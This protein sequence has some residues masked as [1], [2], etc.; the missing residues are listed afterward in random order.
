MAVLMGHFAGI[1]DRK[2]FVRIAHRWNGTDTC[3]PLSVS[4]N[5]AH[6]SN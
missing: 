4:S 5:I 2:L 6:M 3:S 1:R